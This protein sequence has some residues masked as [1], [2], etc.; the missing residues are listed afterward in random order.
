MRRWELVSGGSAKFWEIDHAGPAVTVRFGRLQTS[1]Q[2]QT[3][4]LASVEAAAA[5]VAKLV[6]EKEKKGYVA[7]GSAT[8][9]HPT[10]AQATSAAPTA[11]PTT[12]STAS[13]TSQP[14][15]T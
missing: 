9:A 4:E 5:H 8:A 10:T 3:K 11:Q 14:T 12:A 2:T 15:A 1:G 7:V 6:A 13:T